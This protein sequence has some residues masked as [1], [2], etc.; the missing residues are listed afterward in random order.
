MATGNTGD[1]LDFAADVTCTWLSHDGGAT[2]R[3]VLN[4]PGIYEFGDHGGILVMAPHQVRSMHPSCWGYIV[5]G[6][7]GG[8]G[9]QNLGFYGF[10]I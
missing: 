2:W 5:L 8:E 7:G 6:G 9:A 10:N 4:F 1:Y 3:D